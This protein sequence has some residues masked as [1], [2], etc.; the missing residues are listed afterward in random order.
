M[1]SPGEEGGGGTT[2]SPLGAAWARASTMQ[3][4]AAGPRPAAPRLTVLAC[5]AAEGLK[6]GAPQPWELKIPLPYR[7][8][9]VRE[10]SRYVHTS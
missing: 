8:Q 2:C 6:P 7:A 9:S 1:H 10:V 4:E 5:G 3:T